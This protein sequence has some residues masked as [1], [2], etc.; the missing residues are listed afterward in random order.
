MSLL[1]GTLLVVLVGCD[2]AGQSPVLEDRVLVGEIDDDTFVAVVTDAERVVAYV[3]DG[4]PA[5]VRV[6]T[7]FAGTHDGRGFSLTDANGARLD[8]AI[9]G[10]AVRGSFTLAGAALEYA[11]VDAEGEAGLFMADEGEL[12]GGWI[13]HA[14]GGQ[15]GAVLNRT[16]GDIVSAQPIKTSQASVVL[17]VEASPLLRLGAPALPQ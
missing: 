2:G 6:A 14:D 1:G 17:Q 10:E 9:E 8:G 16:T 3:C 15:R 12:R 13:V 4:T 5:T 11:V 7:W